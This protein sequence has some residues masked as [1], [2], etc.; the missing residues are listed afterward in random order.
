M[1]HIKLYFPLCRDCAAELRFAEL[2]NYLKTFKWA[3]SGCLLLVL[4][5]WCKEGRCSNPTPVPAHA[6]Q[7]AQLPQRV[8]WAWEHPRLLGLWPL[9]LILLGVGAGFRWG[10]FN[11]W[12][13][14]MALDDSS[15]YSRT[16]GKLNPHQTRY[17]STRR[18]S[19]PPDILLENDFKGKFH[20]NIRNIDPIHPRRTKKR[21]SIFSGR[22]CYFNSMLVQYLLIFLVIEG[23]SS[24]LQSELN[25]VLKPKTVFID[26]F[27]Q[28][29]FLL[30]YVSH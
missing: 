18:R 30:N 7:P 16:K 21:P 10:G 20:K 12:C 23:F 4:F 5:H 26:R 9:V 17:K 19:L 15:L 28:V 27:N 14:M 1:P 11:T 25:S 8:S 2:P 3:I 13:S 24:W 22:K 6:Y 29:L